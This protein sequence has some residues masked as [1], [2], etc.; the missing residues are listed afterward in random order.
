MGTANT[1][2]RRNG[3]P[4]SG[5]QVD[6]SAKQIGA[7]KEHSYLVEAP[8]AHGG[9]QRS[10]D[11]EEIGLVLATI[12][13]RVRI[14]PG[15]GLG[16]RIVHV[17]LMLGILNLLPLRQLRVHQQF[18][19]PEG[20]Q[21]LHVTPSDHTHQRKLVVELDPL[22]P[23]CPSVH[24]LFVRR[25]NDSNFN[26][27]HPHGHLGVQHVLRLDNA[28]L[29]NLGN[30]VQVGQGVTH[31]AQVLVERAQLTGRKEGYPIAAVLLDEGGNH[32][33]GGVGEFIPGVKLL[34][35]SHHVW[36]EVDHILLFVG[37]H[38][39]VR[40]GRQ[41]DFLLDVELRIPVVEPLLD[42][43]GDR[44]LLGVEEIV[45]LELVD[46]HGGVHV[47]DFVRATSRL[48]ITTQRRRKP[49][50]RR[51][52]FCRRQAKLCSRSPSRISTCKRWNSWAL[53]LSTTN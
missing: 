33:G 18:L 34:E 26:R 48:R 28:R 36:N 43:L 30:V 17:L 5:L 47:S 10:L 32:Q 25:R 46:D 29:K 53:R 6:G 35:P 51:S 42:V 52:A 24:V 12:R 20:R 7:I 8:I 31:V 50:R 16:L 49:G 9:E 41:C 39:R 37:F 40:E 27:S 45:H 23:V 21:L 19:P 44:V 1:N 2:W 38:L 15:G 14:R 4:A 13:V 22:I 3:I 11:H